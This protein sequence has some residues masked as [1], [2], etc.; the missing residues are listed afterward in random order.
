MS[1]PY[2]QIHEW[3]QAERFDDVLSAV[4]GAD[5]KLKPPFDQDANHGWY[6]VGDILFRRGDHQEALT[7]FES[8]LEAYPKDM[9]ALWASADCH[10]RMKNFSRAEHCL[11]EALTLDPA[12][13]SLLY[14]L[15]NA[16]FDQR[17]F[18]EAIAVYKAVKTDDAELRS[19]AAQNI[20]T[21]KSQL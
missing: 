2:D 14:N 17:K 8:A 3:L 15:G 10:S 20:E 16:L 19:R 12:N 9:E 5:R 1:N 21:A 11:K 4:L 7:A 6:I 18:A 13:P